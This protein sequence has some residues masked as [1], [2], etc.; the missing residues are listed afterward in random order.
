MPDIE[1]EPTLLQNSQP[2]PDCPIIYSWAGMAT[3]YK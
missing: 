2:K 1:S 3:H